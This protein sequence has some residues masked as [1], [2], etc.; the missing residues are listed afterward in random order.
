MFS[1]KWVKITGL[2]LSL[3]SVIFFSSFSLM[4]LVEMEIIEKIVGIIIFFAIVINILVLII[5]YTYGKN[6]N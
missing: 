1:K 2:A 5:F 6:K 4:K 3:P